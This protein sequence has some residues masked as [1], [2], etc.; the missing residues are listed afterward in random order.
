MR[1]LLLYPR[2]PKSFWSFDKAIE[3]MGKKTQSPPLGLITVAAI[4]PQEWEFKLVDLNIREVAEEE[5]AWAEIVMISAMIVQRADFFIQINEAKRRGKKVAVGGP[6]PTSFINDVQNSG[7][8]YLV[9]DEGEMTVP[10]FLE[11]IARG[12]Q[13]GL[14]RSAEKPD[15]Q[16]TPTPRYD[17]LELDAYMEMP[18]QF[19]RGCPFRCEFCDIIVLYGRKPRTKAPEQI[20]RELECLYKLGWRGT[21]SM[22][23]DNFIGNKRDVEK[24]LQVLKP[25]MAEKKYPF[26]FYTEASLNLAEHQKL[27]KLMTE[28]NFD[29][30]F[31]GVETPD[32][33]SLNLINKSQNLRAPISESVAAIKKAGMHITA[34]FIIG[35]DGEEAGAGRRVIQFV[36]ENA[37]PVAMFNLLQA[38]P[39]TQLWYR[40]QKENRL[41]GDIDG[42][43]TSLINFVP[44][45]PIEE[46][47]KEYVEGFWEL[48]EPKRYIERSYRHFMQMENINRHLESIPFGWKE[49]KA[50][51]RIFWLQGV[52]RKTRWYFWYYLF[53][54]MRFNRNMVPDYLL[55]CG[56]ME[57]FTEFRYLVRDQI[58]A[59]LT[60]R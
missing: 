43:Q 47:A 8:D 42:N 10:P 33:E 1:T 13:N 44:T 9:L 17:L 22:V 54:I 35:F 41:I 19:S 3:L 60:K 49:F 57:H 26:V 27:M 31:I 5:W 4:L 28:C 7:A 21:T 56:L 39:N 40:L 16:K 32:K 24:L 11:A 48:Y 20:L 50:L 14:F 34:G 36:E 45:R 52:T 12:E 51:T 25:W 23:D 53:K 15:I 18:V 30:V 29:T 38:L 2:F 59:Q 55:C 37:L 6:F 46:I 58:N